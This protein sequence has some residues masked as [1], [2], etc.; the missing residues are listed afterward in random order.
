MTNQLELTP[1]YCNNLL[2][3]MQS[4]DK[5]N[6]TVAAEM[7]KYI[8]VASNL[9]YLLI[10]Y[11][12]STVEVRNTVFMEEVYRKLKSICRHVDFDVPV[13]YTAIFNEIIYHNVSNEALDY[14]LDIFSVTLKQKMMEWGFSF[15]K[16]YNIKLFKDYSV[17]LI[18]N[19]NESSGFSSKD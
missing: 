10:L 1:E 17:K 15:L 13:T 7:I 14:F 3:M 12:E 6:L 19:N 11:K 8:D 18:S 9:P 5:D 2:K 4:S 16:D